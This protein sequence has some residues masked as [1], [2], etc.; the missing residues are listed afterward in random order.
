MKLRTFDELLETDLQSD[1]SD[2][3]FAA[4]Y[5][6]ACLEE[7]Q[8]SGDMGVFLLA[9]RDVVT[10]THSV[11][12]VA[13]QAGKTRAS[14]YKSFGSKGNPQFATVLQMLPALGIK[15]QFVPDNVAKQKQV[16]EAC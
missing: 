8:A 15:L 11:A 4:G 13:K 7:A 6:Q 5:L 9:L 14:F 3:S 2:P 12:K 16:S 1:L 10:A